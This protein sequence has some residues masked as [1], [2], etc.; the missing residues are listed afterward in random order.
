MASTPSSEEVSA[1]SV[2]PEAAGAGEL[3]PKENNRP[4]VEPASSSSTVRTS[5]Q[6]LRQTQTR[7]RTLK[8]HSAA[9]LEKICN[10]YENHKYKIAFFH[11]QISLVC[12]GLSLE[13]GTRE[14][15][16]QSTELLQ[17]LYLR[18]LFA[19][20]FGFFAF[21]V[22]FHGVFSALIY[23]C[24]VPKIAEVCLPEK[25]RGRVGGGEDGLLVVPS[26]T[27]STCSCNTLCGNRRKSSRTKSSSSAEDEEKSLQMK[28]SR[29]VL[30]T[31]AAGGSSTS[32]EG[33]LHSCTARSLNAN[34]R[35]KQ[36]PDD[37]VVEA[38]QVKVQIALAGTTADEEDERNIFVELWS[39]SSPSTQEQDIK[40]R[41]D[42]EEFHS[43]TSNEDESAQLGQRPR[44]VNGE[45]NPLEEDLD[46]Q[47]LPLSSATPIDR[48]KQLHSDVP[49]PREVDTDP[50]AE[51][52]RQQRR[53]ENK[54]SCPPSW[55]A[56]QI[57]LFLE[58][59]SMKVKTTTDSLSQAAIAAVLLSF[60]L[61]EF[62][63]MFLL[64][65]HGST[66]EN[67]GKLNFLAFT[68]LLAG[69]LLLVLPISLQP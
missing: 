33:P 35:H 48:N 39:S 23:E 14:E 28:Q 8:V 51:A 50:L 25:W 3:Y 9:A 54:K 34:N 30:S 61:L 20:F 65:D 4:H 2:A 16:E 68:L 11:L 58:K 12:Y 15:I 57:Q 26:R 64:Q 66:Y 37:V 13:G 17:Q 44:K 42:E 63:V 47:K 10:F 36:D 5:P 21:A 56:L 31:M 19:F 41:E 62:T 1:V 46:L 45:G 53:L 49:L 29:V 67:H 32:G 55:Y 18:F 52:Q 69:C 22:L 38:Q 60:G 40:P 7:L 24:V 59:F 6:L 43:A 27:S